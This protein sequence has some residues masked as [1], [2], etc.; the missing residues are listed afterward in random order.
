SNIQHSTSNF[1]RSKDDRQECLS[2]RREREYPDEMQHIGWRWVCPKC[3]KEV[4]KIYYPV[5]VKTMF[6]CWFTDPVIQKRLCDADLPQG[7]PAAFACGDCH[8]VYFFSSIAPGAWN[9]VIG[10]LTA[11]M[12]YGCEVERPESFVAER[13]RRRIRIMNCEAPV[14]R[15]VL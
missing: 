13:K 9:E 4:K 3:K 8:G 10:Y 12:L 6:D 15:K 14:R 2:Q 1:Q 7:P 11:G 5:A